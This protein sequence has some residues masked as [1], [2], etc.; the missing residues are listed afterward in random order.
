MHE[1]AICRGIIDQVSA[2]AADHNA[3]HVDR[4]FLKIGPLS[5]V[6]PEL[7][8]SAFPIASAQ[9]VASDATLVIQSLPVRVRCKS[10]SA[11]SE[12]TINKMLCSQCGDWQTELLSG[13]EML[14]ERIELETH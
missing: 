11:E 13:D 5:G 1:L 10:C 3:Q 8:R 7:L 14:L 4:I 12:V 6:E 9:T 2:I